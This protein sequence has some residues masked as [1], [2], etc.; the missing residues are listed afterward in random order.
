MDSTP[1]ITTIRSNSLFT[2]EVVMRFYEAVRYG[3]KIKQA[4]QYAGISA[5]LYYSWRRRGLAGDEPYNIFIKGV[6]QAQGEF[7]V[8]N[9]EAVHA[10]SAIDWKASAWLLERRYPEDFA[11]RQY[12][13]EEPALL[14]DLKELV[15]GGLV[16]LKEI[17]A[18]MPDLP[19]EYLTL[20]MAL[21][22]QL[23]ESS[24][25]FVD[26]TGKKADI[27]EGQILPTALQHKLNST[28]PSGDSN[29][30]A[31]VLLADDKEGE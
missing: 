7:V 5:S 14:R 22:A 24:E 10:H 30:S 31:P 26:T 6:E 16:T 19:A 9:L 3:S 12:I 4:C 13:E 29:K 23:I 21:E 28:R 25:A 8:R 2:K 15:S 11:M 27:I 1:R 18:E 17:K 20:L